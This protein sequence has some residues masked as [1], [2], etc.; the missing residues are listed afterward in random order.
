MD[1]WDVDFRSSS[2]ALDFEYFHQISDI[3]PGENKLTRYELSGELNIPLRKGF[4]LT[5]GYE[6]EFYLSR[7]IQ[8]VRSLYLGFGFKR[9]LSLTL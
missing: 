6:E 9:L 3:I 2:L 7:N 1:F 8:N 4:Q 5:V